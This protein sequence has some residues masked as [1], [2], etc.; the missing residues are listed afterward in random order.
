MGEAKRRGTYEERKNLA[1][2]RNKMCAAHK[3]VTSQ[4]KI[5]TSQGSRAATSQGSR[6]VHRAL[7][8]GL[9]GAALIQPNTGE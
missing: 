5:D 9:I 7:L 2:D 3:A 4:V 6:A 8:A 1:I